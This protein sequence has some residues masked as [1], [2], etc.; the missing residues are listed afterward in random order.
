[1]RRPD[2]TL[3]DSDRPVRRELPAAL[4]AIALVL[5]AVGSLSGA[6]LITSVAETY[7]V[8]FAAAQWTLTITLL[9]GAVTTPFLGRLGSGRRRRPTTLATLAVVTAGSVCTVVPGS[10]ALLLV[11]RAAQGVGLGLA[12]L[13]M[14]T[15]RDAF[16]RS[17]AASVIA[18]LSVASTAGVGVGYPLAGLLTDLHGVRAAYLTG[19]VASA[20]ATAVAVRVLP[21]ATTTERP[22]RLDWVGAVLLGGALTALLVPLGDDDLWSRQPTVAATLLVCGLALMVAWVVVERRTDSPL[23]DLR[24]LRHPVVL[25][26][27]LAMF[28]GGV[29]MYLLLTL[30][31]RYVQTPEAAGYGFGL[32]TLEAGLFLVPFSVAGFAAGRFVPWAVRRV[33]ATRT[34]AVS[35]TLVVAGFLVFAAGRATIAGPALALTVLGVGVGGFSAAMPAMILAAT[36][37]EETASAMGVNQVVRSAGFALGSALGGLVLSAYS[38]GHGFPREHG[39][40]A[41]GLGGAAVM[42]LT[43]LVIGVGRRSESSSRAA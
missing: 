39:Y 15:A 16:D 8:S 5:A 34:V 43:L 26:A 41:A 30:V 28:V 42:A 25:R 9:T 20:A 37:P 2:S 38:S 4:L 32:N 12:P 29:G 22:P 19:L 40:L 17:R 23:V 21:P 35:A 27:D 36:P 10:F 13:L 3:P 14:A 33:G 6:P 18:L 7:D 11:G 1:V 24:A 31:T